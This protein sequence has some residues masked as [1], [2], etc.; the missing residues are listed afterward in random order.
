M[1]KAKA[2]K[3]ETAAGKEETADA[4]LAALFDAA[5]PAR[6]TRVIAVRGRASTISRTSI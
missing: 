1:A 6:D 4:R 5:P 3:A 2:R